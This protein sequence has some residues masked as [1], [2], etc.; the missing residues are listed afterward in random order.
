MLL[1]FEFL[2]HLLWVSFT[3]Y[4]YFLLKKQQREPAAEIR[5]EANC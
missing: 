5:T 3:F 2:A 1:F 4:S